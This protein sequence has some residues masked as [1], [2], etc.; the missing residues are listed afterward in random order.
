MAKK[1]AI[2][3]TVTGNDEK[4]GFRALVMK[5]A[6]EYNLAGIARNEP[7][8]VVKFTL[9]GNKH[10]IASA[11]DVIQ[12]GTARSSDLKIATAPIAIDDNLK[13]FTIVDWTS[14]SRGIT[15]AYTLVFELRAD[16]DDS[17][18]SETDTKSVWHGIL[19]KTLDAA[20]LQKLHPDD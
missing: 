11:L 8:A 2:A 1:E 13:T 20:D 14:S 19:A 5:Q 18:I 4:V 6:I 12:K 16:D 3:A 9:Q 15:N 10:R 17:E 7:N